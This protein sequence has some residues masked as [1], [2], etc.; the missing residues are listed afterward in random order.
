MVKENESLKTQMKERDEKSREHEL[1]RAR[2]EAEAS[3]LKQVNE[4]SRTGQVQEWSDSQWQEFESK[5]GM[6]RA[7]Y[8]ANASVANSM[9]EK[10]RQEF[11]GKMSATE[12]RARKA[13]ERAEK[14]ERERQSEGVEKDFFDNKPS[15]SRYKSEVREFAGKFPEADRRDPAK[16]KDILSM[17]ET[18]V[19]GKV[20]DKMKITPGGS[21]RLGAGEAIEE[22]SE[23][24]DMTGL[25]SES[26]Q[27][28]VRELHGEVRSRDK[29]LKP[30][31][32]STGKG[33]RVSGASEWAEQKD[34]IAKEFKRARL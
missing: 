24:V 16:Y 22:S 1:A 17:A 13:E 19:R 5:T 3:A 18:Y 11:S 9:T 12:E 15:L 34:A 27:R 20:G 2:A 30:F 25:E 14:L 32:S 4:A 7:A 6:T 26:Q 8:L 29:E 33:I 10:L 28:L 21:P 23:D 31:E